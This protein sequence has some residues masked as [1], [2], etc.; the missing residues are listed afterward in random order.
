MFVGDSAFGD[1]LGFMVTVRR[2]W[3]REP[4]EAWQTRQPLG[5]S[6]PPRIP[7]IQRRDPVT[8]S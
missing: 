3:A 2:Y 1:E 4:L 8:A 5:R 7:D 6:T